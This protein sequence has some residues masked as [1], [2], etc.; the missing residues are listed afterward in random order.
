MAQKRNTDVDQNV[1]EVTNV[2]PP[3]PFQQMIKA[4]AMEATAAAEN[5]QF[6]GDELTPMLTAETEDDIWEADERGPLNFQHLVGCE[7]EIIDVEVKYS[8]GSNAEIQTPF[9]TS[10]GKKMYLLV[11]LARV[12]DATERREIRLPE[13]GE[14]FQAN[15]SAKYVTTKIWMFYV[16]GFINR[17]QGKTLEA[18]IRETELGDGTAVL[19]LRPIP[20][21]PLIRTVTE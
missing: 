2:N 12:S 6:T 7:V 10:D 5:A 4:M 19:K 14:I 20:R 3:T 1:T 9:I 8:R 13:I 21:R 11:T 16:R 18:T 15:T 17:D